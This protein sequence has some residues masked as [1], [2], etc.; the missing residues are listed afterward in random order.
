M[1]CQ[2][3]SSLVQS[4][5]I[6]HQFP[7]PC[8]LSFK[9]SEEDK[10]FYKESGSSYLPSHDCRAMG[11][12]SKIGLCL[13]Q[14]FIPIPFLQECAIKPLSIPQPSTSSTSPLHNSVSATC[15][16]VLDSPSRVFSL[17]S[18]KSLSLHFLFSQNAFFFNNRGCRVGSIA[19]RDYSEPEQSSQLCCKPSPRSQSPLK[20]DLQSGGTNRPPNSNPQSRPASQ[21]PPAL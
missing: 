9:K 17:S 3:S 15:N 2:F 8:L 19:V 7:R 13:L 5:H 12:S 18:F 20:R 14:A 4:V 11:A 16:T 1:N 21:A 6:S 10:A